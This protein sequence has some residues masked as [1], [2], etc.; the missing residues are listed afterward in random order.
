VLPKGASEFTIQHRFGA[1]EL[2]DSFI[3]DF[4]G[5]DLAS[6]VRFAYAMAI[7]EKMYA[8]IGRTKYG[9]VYDLGLK[10]RF[11]QQTLDNKHPVNIAVYANT[12]ISTADFPRLVEGSTFESG[13]VFEYSFAHRLSYNAQVIVSRKF[14]DKFSMQIAPVMIWRN[15]VQIEEEQLNMALPIGAR[16]RLNNKSALLLEMTPKLLA[17]D[18]QIP[19]ALTYEIASSSAHAFQIVLA[20]TDG[21]LEQN[22]YTSPIYDYSKGKFVLGFN[23]KRLF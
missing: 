19:L 5:T 10:Y 17:S 21:I 12:G 18:K 20:S 14:S 9:K 23:I 8:E 7:N 2:N 6:N 4:L 22:I 16:L 3:K 1:T 11:L 15:L 13:E